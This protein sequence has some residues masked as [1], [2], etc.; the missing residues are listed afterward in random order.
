MI[1][2]ETLA[3]K[4]VLITGGTGTLGRALVK[5]IQ[6]KDWGVPQSIII[7]SRGEDEQKEMAEEFNYDLLRFVPGYIRY[8]RDHRKLFETVQ[9]VIHCAAM[10]DIVQCEDYPWYAIEANV[11]GMF[12]VLASSSCSG[13]HIERFVFISSDK[14]VAPIGVYGCTKMLGE[15]LTL[16]SAEGHTDMGDPPICSVVRLVN[17]WGSSGSVVPLFRRQIAEGGPLTITDVNMMRWFMWPSDAAAFILET[18]RDARQG[19][20]AIPPGYAMRIMDIATALMIE[21]DKDVEIKI[22]GRRPGEK[23]QEA[24]VADYELPRYVLRNYPLILPAFNPHPWGE[25]KP[26]KDAGPQGYKLT[27][28]AIV[29]MIKEKGP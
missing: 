17:L 7:F 14:A 1:R 24:K 22:I 27:P 25:D 26:L 10:K 13:P 18:L 16:I 29:R 3:G 8:T 5:A 4:N 9:I 12:S 21:A 6:T 20:I 15:R 28:S 11:D 2:E 23:L 19:E